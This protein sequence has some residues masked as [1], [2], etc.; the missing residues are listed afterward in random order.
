LGDQDTNEK[1]I[2][3][4][5]FSTSNCRMDSKYSGEGSTADACDQ[6]VYGA[7]SFLLFRLYKCDFKP[8]PG[9]DASFSFTRAKTLN[10][11]A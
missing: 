1:L 2:S 9:T 8:T 6:A 5:D 11:P 7:N 4:W 3:T 10:H